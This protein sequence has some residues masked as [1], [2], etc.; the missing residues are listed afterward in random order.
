MKTYRPRI[1]FKIRGAARCGSS[2]AGSD[3]ATSSRISI[4]SEMLR[5]EDSRSAIRVVGFGEKPRPS[6]GDDEQIKGGDG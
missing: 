6:M 4:P 2:G 1:G 3:F 5:R